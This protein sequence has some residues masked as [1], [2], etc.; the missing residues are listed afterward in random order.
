[1]D[2]TK[3][4]ICVFALIIVKIRIIAIIH[5]IRNMRQIVHIHIIWNIVM[6]ALIAKIASKCF[7]LKIVWNVTIPIFYIIVP[8][9]KTALAA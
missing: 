3:I 2:G 1:V 5:I 8:I 9:A 4:V 6:I 7:T